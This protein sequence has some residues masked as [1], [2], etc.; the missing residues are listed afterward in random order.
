MEDTQESVTDPQTENQPEVLNEDEKV[1]RK[2]KLVLFLSVHWRGIV[3]L[4][5]PLIFIAVLAPFPPKKYQWCAYTLLIMAV[6]WVTECIPLPIT[7]FLPIVIF[8]M[9]DVMDT[10]TTCMCYMN[11]TILMFYG[12]MVLAYAVEQSGLHKR[13]ALSAIRLIGYS[14]YR[15]LLAMSLTTMFVS[16]WITNTAATT[17]MVPIIFALLKVFEDLD[18]ISTFEEDSNGDLTA[19]DITTCYFCGASFSATIGGIGTLVGSATNL[20]FKGLYERAFPSA[21]DYLSFPKYSAFSVPFML[22]LE[23]GLYFTMVVRFFGFL[24]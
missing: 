21:P 3:C 7:S 2:R 14:H 8:P 15:L 20:V 23:A 9:T 10:R 13:L 22:V 17:M 5:T 12:S 16:M 6:F 24:R 4:V 11:D 19:S 1:S 18:L